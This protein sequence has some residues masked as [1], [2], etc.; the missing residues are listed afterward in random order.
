MPGLSKED[1]KVTVE[2][3]TRVIKDEEL[4]EGEGEGEGDESG[5]RRCSSRLELPSN[6]YKLDG[7]KGEMKNGVFDINV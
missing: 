7:I 2:K 1:A 4:M 5:R 6:L 3:N